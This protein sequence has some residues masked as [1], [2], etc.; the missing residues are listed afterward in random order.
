MVY[1]AS[2][3]YYRSVTESLVIGDCTGWCV[4]LFLISLIFV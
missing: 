1:F 4:V 3:M 2:L